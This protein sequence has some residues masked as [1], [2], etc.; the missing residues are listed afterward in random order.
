MPARDSDRAYQGGEPVEPKQ[1]IRGS[2]RGRVPSG[3]I[4]EFGEGQVR[5]L[6]S[7]VVGAEGS[8]VVLE[9][10][11][12]PLGLAVCLRVVGGRYSSGA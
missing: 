11:V 8:E 6:I 2:V 4:H 10:L 9:V 1:P 12:L 5:R 7:L 3:V